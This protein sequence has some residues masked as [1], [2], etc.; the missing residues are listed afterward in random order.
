M[1][2]TEYCGGGERV[3]AVEKVFLI[4]RRNFSGA[5]AQQNK[6]ALALLDDIQADTIG[7]DDPFGRFA[8]GPRPTKGPL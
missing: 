1:G 2:A 7:L 5:V 4:D 3:D 8:H 6:R